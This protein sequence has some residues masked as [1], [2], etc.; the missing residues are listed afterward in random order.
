MEH[1]M[2]VEVR[3]SSRALHGGRVIARAGPW[4]SSGCWW[5]HGD[6]TSW[7]RDEWDVELPD[8]VFRLSLDRAKGRW[9]IDGAFD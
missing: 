2:P 1:G 7:D 5:A 8:G 3:L 9:E 4:R 6:R